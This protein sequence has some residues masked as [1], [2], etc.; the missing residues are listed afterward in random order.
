LVKARV[1]SAD[2]NSAYGGELAM[3]QKIMFQDNLYQL[4]RSIDTVYEGMLLDLSPDFFFDKTVDDILFF[5]ASIRKL[6]SY[7]AENTQISGYIK[8]LHALHACQ[9]RYLQLIDT[10]LSEKSTMQENFVPLASKLREIR[11][12][13]VGIQTDIVRA[14][15]KIDK[16]NDS[17]DIVSG[18]ELSELLNF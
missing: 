8:L 10:I 2:R 16:N 9:S 14:I 6:A 11:T 3:M 17:R 1:F 7:F 15:G 13:H 12:T 5:D 4:S 18:D